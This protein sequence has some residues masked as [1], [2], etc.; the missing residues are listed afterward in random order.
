M[1][2]KTSFSQQTLALL[3]CCWAKQALL[4][5]NVWPLT[6]LWKKRARDGG[7]SKNKVV[8][9]REVSSEAG[10][11]SLLPSVKMRL[12]ES[13]TVGWF[14]R[15]SDAR[16]IKLC[17]SSV[18]WKQ[19]NNSSFVWV[20]AGAFRAALRV[21]T[22]NRDSCWMQGRTDQR[23]LEVSCRATSH[24]LLLVLMIRRPRFLEKDIWR[25][26]KYLTHP[27]RGNLRLSEPAN[28]SPHRQFI[29]THKNRLKIRTRQSQKE[30]THT[31]INGSGRTTAGQQ[32]P[33]RQGL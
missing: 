21:S 22:H 32:H 1:K 20:T 10:F 4:K 15:S 26:Q 11:N 13:F 16:P 18:F 2:I 24:F 9:L 6:S 27:S 25:I 33:A 31:R 7:T 23:L 14:G 3:K 29:Y 8:G 17:R 28:K 12:R 5:L 30:A 19:P